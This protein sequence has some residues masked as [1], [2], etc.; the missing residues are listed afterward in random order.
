MPTCHRFISQPKI[1]LLNRPS[2]LH[3]VHKIY[4]SEVTRNYIRKISLTCFAS[5][6]NNN[7]P[8]NGKLILI[9]IRCQR[10]FK[11]LSISQSQV[12]ATNAGSLVLQKH[13]KTTIS[14][15]ILQQSILTS[16]TH[17]YKYHIG[18][19]IYSLPRNGQYHD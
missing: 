6:V 2:Y 11:I 12:D 5:T 3:F 14:Y 17:R 13:V 4:Q 1:I 18:T 7:K 19:L 16:H 9:S 15:Y 10:T 8:L